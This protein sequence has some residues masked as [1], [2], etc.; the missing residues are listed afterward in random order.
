MLVRTSFAQ[1]IIPPWQRYWKRIGSLCIGGSSSVSIGD[2]RVESPRRISSRTSISTPNTAWNISADLGRCRSGSGCVCS[3]S[4]RLVDLYRRYLVA[5]ARDAEREVPMDAG[6]G[7][8][9]LA[10]RLV[11]YLT[12]PSRAAIRHESAERLHQ[13]LDCLEPAD[14]E[15]LTLRHFEAMSN[16]AVATRLGLN[17]D[18]AT[19]PVFKNN[20]SIFVVQSPYPLSLGCREVRSNGQ[21]EGEP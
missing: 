1:A 2:C 19:K 7:S 20:F 11:G 14:R 8:A 13:A 10:A 5:R 16:Q 9:V 18:E 12:T 15:V 21:D 3:R 6:I 4:Q 17:R